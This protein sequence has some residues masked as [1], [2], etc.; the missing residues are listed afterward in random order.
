MAVLDRRIGI[1]FLAFVALLGVAVARA[2]YL[3]VFRA[4]ALHRA[5]LTQQV[6]REVVP[7]PRGTITDSG[8][9]QLAIS[10][11]AD[12]VVADPYL[13]K[14]PHVAAERLAPLVGRP[15]PAVYAGLTKPHTGFVY[16]AH[17]VPVA[18]G[19]QIVQLRIN[20]IN[21]IPT[22]RRFYPRSFEASQVLGYVGSQDQGLAGIEYLYN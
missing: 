8:G 17:Q 19:N 18:Q 22:V 7:A 14:D 9:V 1:L 13:I 16:L 21:L 15:V 5:A 6:I 20:G 3:G 4:G 2:A 11:S 10:Q 12:D